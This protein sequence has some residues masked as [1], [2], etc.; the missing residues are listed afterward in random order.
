VQPAV[1]LVASSS[2]TSIG[3]SLLVI[4]DDLWKIY[5]CAGLPDGGLR[6]D[7]RRREAVLA[8]AHA[9]GALCPQSSP[10]V[11]PNR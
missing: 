7:Y 10:I 5:T 6:R 9:F 11:H 8:V 4:D 2:A 1:G 3:G